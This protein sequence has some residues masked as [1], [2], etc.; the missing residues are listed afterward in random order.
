MDFLGIPACSSRA[1]SG[2][3]TWRLGAGRVMSQ[4]EMAALDLLRAS[5]A[6]GGDATG[7]S[8][9][10]S[11]APAG[12]G[13]GRAERASRTRYRYPSGSVTA[14]PV[15][16]NAKSIR[17]F[18]TYHRCRGAETFGAQIALIN[19]RTGIFH[20]L[21]ANILAGFVILCLLLSMVSEPPPAG[22]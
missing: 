20:M 15:F 18:A 8:S 3:R 2:G 12:S 19:I 6:S 10:D 13:K 4:T 14:S 21:V 9:A 1:S 17:I 7:L 11:I 16:P 22:K 5:S